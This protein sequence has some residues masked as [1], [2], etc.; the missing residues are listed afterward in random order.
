V[1]RAARCAGKGT[2]GRRFAF[3]PYRTPAPKPS[4][5][6][7]NP[8][9]AVPWTSKAYV[10]DANWAKLIPV[11]AAKCRLIHPKADKRCEQAGSYV[12]E[13]MNN[14]EKLP[15]LAP[16]TIYTAV[17]NMGGTGVPCRVIAEDDSISG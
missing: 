12:I 9:S 2:G 13:N 1:N 4:P 14:T 3:P 16:F 15:T 5:A 17:F 6:H 8:A 10:G 7:W 11:S